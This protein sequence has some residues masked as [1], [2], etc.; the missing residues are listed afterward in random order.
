MTPYLLNA[1]LA[2][3]SITSFTAAGYV[4]AKFWKETR[5]RLLGIFAIS[6]YLIAFE[7]L[8]LFIYH[9]ADDGTSHLYVIRLGV[10]L[11]IIFGIID[12]N[13]PRR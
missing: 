9:P 2:G 7:R 8:L 13:R 11:L 12:T 3:I 6:F 4:F 10:F 1:M 5:D